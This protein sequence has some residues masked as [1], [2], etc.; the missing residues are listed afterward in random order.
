MCT[1]LHELPADRFHGQRLSLSFLNQSSAEIFVSELFRLL[2]LTAYSTN[3]QSLLLPI[4]FKGSD[5]FSFTDYIVTSSRY[6]S[7]KEQ[8]I[9]GW[10]CARHRVRRQL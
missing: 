2:D 4:P 10:Y 8:A 5:S 9:V 6:F 7:F 1:S 3:A